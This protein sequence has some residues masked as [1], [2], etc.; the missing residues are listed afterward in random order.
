MQWARPPEPGD[1]FVA[2]LQGSIDYVHTDLKGSK[3]FKP[4][5][6]DPGLSP[7]E[8]AAL[9]AA[10][11]AAR[12]HTTSAFVVHRALQYSRQPA[13]AAAYARGWEQGKEWDRVWQSGE[14]KVGAGSWV[15][16]A[17]AGCG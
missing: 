15:L 14:A 5:P 11:A 8:A 2:R 9:A 1:E 13:L 6:P 16:G 3:H 10:E 12:Q 7:K 17:R 4:P